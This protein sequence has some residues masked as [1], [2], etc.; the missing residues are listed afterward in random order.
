MSDATPARPR[1]PWHLGAVAEVTPEIAGWT[2][3][4]LRILPIAPG[5]VYDL[6]TGD[7]EM[8]VLPLSG[9]PVI[10]DVEGRHFELDGRA[11]VFAAVTDWAYLP[12]D[13]EVRLVQR[14]AAPRWRCRR[15]GRRAAST[16]RTSPP[17]TS[18]WRFAAPVR[19]PARSPTSC[20]PKRSTAPTS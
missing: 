3:C 1:H 15:L 2:Y 13:A 19:R 11:T 17:A 14:R 5:G 9:G 20:R 4:G 12:V 18:P 16:R 10:V 8:A 7:A 6:V